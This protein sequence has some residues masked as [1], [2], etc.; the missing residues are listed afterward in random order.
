M[1]NFYE[2]LIGLY[3][4][5]DKQRRGYLFEQLI[6]EIQPWSYRP[7]ISAVGNGEQLDAIYE[8]DGRIFIIEA[9]AKEAKIM[10]SSKEWEDFEL[11]VRRRNK[12]V[13][14]L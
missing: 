14:G 9:K 2:Q 13:V 8:W 4:I 11:K 6:R 1:N 10:Q 5:D 12:S 7:P 3:D